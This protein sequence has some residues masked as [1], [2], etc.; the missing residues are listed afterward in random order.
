MRLEPVRPLRST[1]IDTSSAAQALGNVEIARCADVE[2]P[3]ERPNEARA[4]GAAV[5]LAPGHAHDLEAAAVVQLE[6]LGHQERRGVALEVGRQVGDAKPR[7]RAGAAPQRR[8]GERKPVGHVGPGAFELQGRIVGIADEREGTDDRP[9]LADAPF[10]LG[11]Q[12]L[13]P[14]P[15][16]DAQRSVGDGAQRMPVVGIGGQRPLVARQRLLVAIEEPE[17]QA[18]VI[19]GL[20]MVGRES[21]GPARSWRGRR[22][23]GR[24]PSTQC[25][26]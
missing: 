5:V 22:R 4:R 8:H 6:E 12:P 14:R 7:P 16:A 11:A 19:E 23:G 25:R 26:D 10:Q 13:H 21:R 2:E 9:A 24:G 15:V 17:R 20:G 1:A 3:V 18:L